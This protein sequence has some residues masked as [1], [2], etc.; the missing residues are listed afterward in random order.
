MLTSPVKLA[1]LTDGHIS[2]SIWY[3][4]GTN[5]ITNAFFH[6]NMTS[7]RFLLQGNWTVTSGAPSVH[8]N[9]GLA[10]IVLGEDSGYRVYFH[11]EDGAINELS[12][13]RNSGWEYHGRIS[14]DINSLPAIGA[15]F[16]GKENI[17]VASPRDEENIAATR[18]N[19]DETWYRS[20]VLHRPLP[21]PHTSPPLTSPS[22]PSR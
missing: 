22:L 3:L 16:S 19:K 2:A 9:S 10:A 12:Y 8:S 11:D 15:G 6:C 4:D 17:T 21:S 7:G 5:N 1:S 14:R 18:W 20:M 13:S